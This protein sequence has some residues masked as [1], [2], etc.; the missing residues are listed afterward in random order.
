MRRPYL[1][2]LVVL[3]LVLAGCGGDDSPEPVPAPTQAASAASAPA[4]STA[5]PATDG[6]TTASVESATEPPTGTGSAPASSATAVAAGPPVDVELS[7]EHQSGMTGVA[8]QQP[9][10]EQSFE[11]TMTVRGGDDPAAGSPLAHIHDVTCAQYRALTDIDEQYATVVDPLQDV[12]EHT[13]STVVAA[14]LAARTTGGYSIN[15]HSAAT[16]A[17]IAC[18][19]IP[20][21]PG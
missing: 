13:S 3:T 15:V 19:D 9:I 12:Y 7:A 5:A 6:A 17:T 2:S 11:V 10:D 20:K 16:L 21:Q 8:T 18:G 1:P 4:S 14:P